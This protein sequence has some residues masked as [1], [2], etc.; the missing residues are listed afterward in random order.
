MPPFSCLTFPSEGET[1]LTAWE[2]RDPFVGAHCSQK[3]VQRLRGH[4]HPGAV[5]RERPNSPLT[6]YAPSPASAAPPQPRRRPRPR[7]HDPPA[8]PP[9]PPALP[10]GP[11]RSPSA[12]GGVRTRVRRFPAR[13][14]PAW[15]PPPTRRT[16]PLAVRPRAL[17]WDRR[18]AA[19]A[20]A[21]AARLA[22]RSR[23]EP[24]APPHPPGEYAPPGPRGRG[25]PGAGCRS[26]T[27]RG[28]VGVRVGTWAQRGPGRLGGRSLESLPWTR[29]S[30]EAVS[31]AP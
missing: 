15:P 6:P 25:A 12:P 17:D 8:F 21:P 4:I 26:P 10:P 20:R 23:A 7:P 13:P 2:S 18:S 1:E 5:H 24:P 29:F 11:T 14:G 31:L 22:D 30:R 19:L 27:P 16:G 3:G 28:R 9:P